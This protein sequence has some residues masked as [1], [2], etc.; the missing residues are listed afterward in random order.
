[1]D[2]TVYD[3]ALIP[4]IVGLIQL[5]K[6][7]GLPTKFSPILGIILGI[8]A[9]SIFVYPNDIKGGILGGIM[10]GLSTTGLY[11]GTKNTVEFIKN[12]NNKINI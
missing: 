7:L 9:G 8:V 4:V 5:A 6:G 2:L 3:V 11:S 12:D 10:I 1:M